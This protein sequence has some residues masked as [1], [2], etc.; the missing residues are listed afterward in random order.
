M[1]RILEAV[2]YVGGSW[3]LTFLS[4][5]VIKGDL[6]LYHSDPGELFGSTNLAG[7]GLGGRAAM[8]MLVGLGTW[9]CGRRRRYLGLSFAAAAAVAVVLAGHRGTVAGITGGLAALWLA[10]ARR[11]RYRP[12]A[13]ITA[14]L[15]MSISAF[16]AWR[17]APTFIRG[18]YIEAFWSES[19]EQR[20]SDQAVSLRAWVES[21]LI[22]HGTGSSAYI[23]ARVDQPQFGVVQGIYPHN[24]VVELLAETGSIGLAIYLLAVGGVLALGLRRMPETPWYAP[25]LFAPAVHAFVTSQAGADLT[26]HNDLW[27]LLSLLAG[28]VSLPNDRR[29]AF[30]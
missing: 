27:I 1:E 20:L 8:V 10:M 9:V 6:N 2:L 19:L 7:G 22:G 14:V 11:R 3:V 16:L 17:S 26:I 4:I 21:P 29:R 30:P 18:R 23:I 28:A 12:V 13:A 25:V 15:V 5:A 24:V